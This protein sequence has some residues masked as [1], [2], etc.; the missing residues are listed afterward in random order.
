MRCIYTKMPVFFNK[1]L[2]KTLRPLERNMHK[3]ERLCIR[4][5]YLFDV[6]REDMRSVNLKFN[7]RF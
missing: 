5:L 6:R 7:E 3:C 2:K 1:V 4:C